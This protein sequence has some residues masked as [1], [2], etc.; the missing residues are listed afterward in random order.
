MGR[1]GDIT[2]VDWTGRGIA[3]EVQSSAKEMQAEDRVEPGRPKA[4]RRKVG[5]NRE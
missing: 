3:I 4:E 1:T 5:P 2:R